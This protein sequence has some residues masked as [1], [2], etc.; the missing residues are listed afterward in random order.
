MKKALMV[1]GHTD[2][3]ESV[4]NRTILETLKRRLPDAGILIELLK[5]L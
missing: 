5:T 2:L 3:S 1:S 4:A